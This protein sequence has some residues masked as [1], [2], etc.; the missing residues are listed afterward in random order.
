M[1][2]ES[3]IRTLLLPELSF[4]AF[5]R[6]PD[7]RAI[8]VVAN[9]TP[10][11]EYCPHCA[12]P[13][14][15]T[16]DTRKVT[17]KDEPLRT[18]R[19]S[20]IVLKRRLWC[21]PCGKPFTEPL[22]WARKGF[23]HTERYARAVMHACERYVDLKRVRDDFKC[24]GGWLYSA[25]YRHLELERR[26]RLYPWPPKIGIDEHFFR[27]GKMGFRDFVS[28]IVDQK[29]HR[30]MEVVEGRTGAELEAALAYIPGRENV[31]AVAIDMCDPFKSFAKR[32]FPNAT[33]VA[34]KFHVLRL[35]S[36]AINRHR[37]AITGDRRTL[38][39]RRL[40]L[41]NGRD[42]EPRA[43][44]ALRTWL[45]D[46]PTLRELYDAKEAL[47]GFYRIRS[48][49]QAKRVF[50]ELTDRLARSSVAE[51]QTFRTTL[52]R[53]RSEVLAYFRTRSTNG[54]TEGF[55]GKAKLV[56]RRAYGYRSFTNYRLRLLNACA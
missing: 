35:L 27:R 49:E 31:R 42:L 2:D 29:N 41:R 24:S 1:P 30:L 5:R 15:S 23:R 36:P 38:P 8:E 7:T 55:N 28:V 37:K 19:V 46:H 52:M 53:W 10:Q 20:L 6:I 45:A 26:K 34:D 17:L 18:F 14:T 47:A 51:I 9:K 43:R 54:M 11:V 13:S 22:P 12:T 32:F 25:L 33:I 48:Y 50:T 3:L 44:W 56:K 21:R 40:L 16:Y 39:V 4:I